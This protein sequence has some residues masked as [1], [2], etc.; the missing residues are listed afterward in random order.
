MSPSRTWAPRVPAVSSGAPSMRRSTHPPCASP[1]SASASPQWRR[2]LGSRSATGTPAGSAISA[3]RCGAVTVTRARS[4]PGDPPPTGTAACPR[5]VVAWPATG[6]PSPRRRAPATGEPV[7]ARFPYHAEAVRSARQAAY[8]GLG[9]A[10]GEHGCD[11]PSSAATGSSLTG[12]RDRPGRAAADP[13]RGGSGLVTVPPGHPDGRGQLRVRAAVHV[14]GQPDRAVAVGDRPDVRGVHARHAGQHLGHRQR[15]AQER[16]G[17]A[18]ARLHAVPVLAAPPGPHHYPRAAAGGVLPASRPGQA[19]VDGG[20]Y[21]ALGAARRR[22]RR[23]RGTGGAGRPGTGHAVDRPAE[24]AA[25][26]SG[27]DVRGGAA[28]VPEH[29]R[30]GTRPAGGGVA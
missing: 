11:P 3:R 26:G 25:G 1:E 28:T 10:R 23:R 16:A 24:P 9:V 14:L 7:T 6:F 29:L 13:A 5:P 22:S 30:A 15:A 18:A 8:V 19:V 4:T 20:Q 12:R 21:P 2:M 27:A 17:G